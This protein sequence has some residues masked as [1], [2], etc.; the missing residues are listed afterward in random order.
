[1]KWGISMYCINCGSECEQFMDGEVQRYR[2][3]SC[4]YISYKNPSPCVSILVV[5]DQGQVLLGK[6]HK[7]SIFPEKWCLPCGYIEYGETYV[8]AAIR[9]VKEEVGITVTL[10]GIINVVSNCFEIGVSSLVIV[11]LAKYHG[12]EKPVPGDDI[13]ETDWFDLDGTLPCLAFEA[14]EFIIAKYRE[15]VKKY[16]EITVLKLEGNAF[17]S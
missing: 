4:N 1:M 11:L 7:A 13:T 8:D 9:E 2:C 10:D 6:R 17:S 15:S 3:P 16:G 5:N 12:S 14:D